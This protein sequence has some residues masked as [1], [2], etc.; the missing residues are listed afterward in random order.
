MLSD[1]EI[2]AIESSIKEI[3]VVIGRAKKRQGALRSV[4]KAKAN[5]SFL[6]RNKKRDDHK[7][8]MLR[9]RGLTIRKIAEI[10]GVSPTVVHRALATQTDEV[11]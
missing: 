4:E 7:I 8:R 5:G 9:K 11:T 3:Q 2:N 10:E 6:G 1:N